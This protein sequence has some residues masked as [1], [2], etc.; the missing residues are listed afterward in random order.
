MIWK[1]R[2]KNT[3]AEQQKEKNFQKWGELKKHFNIHIMGI[4]EE[5]E[6]EQG[7]ESLFEEI[8]T[9]NFPNLVREKDTQ[10]QEAQR[11]PN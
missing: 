9:K 8:I 4:P 10:V 2:Y 3:Q 1:T 7:I 11:V 6:S 5:E